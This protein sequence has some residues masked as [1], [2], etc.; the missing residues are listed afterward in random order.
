MEQIPFRRQLD[1]EDS[2]LVPEAA[3]TRC[4]TAAVAKDRIVIKAGPHRFSVED[5]EDCIPHPVLYCEATEPAGRLMCK[6]FLKLSSQRPIR[7]R[8]GHIYGVSSG[9]NGCQEVD[10]TTT[11]RQGNYL[12]LM[13]EY[14]D[15]ATQ[16]SHE[17]PTRW[18]P[19]ATH[20]PGADTARLVPQ[21]LLA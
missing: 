3:T 18:G 5:P 16:V 20:R 8:A 19:F 9:K 13:H 15:S 17:C 11:R 14:N 2:K 1:K 7:I 4:P 21:Q 12:V 6:L 10:I